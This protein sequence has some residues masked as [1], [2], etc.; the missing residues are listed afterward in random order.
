MGV[1]LSDIGGTVGQKLNTRMQLTELKSMRSIL[2]SEANEK[3]MNAKSDKEVEDVYVDYQKRLSAI[4]SRSMQVAIHSSDLNEDNI[5]LQQNKKKAQDEYVLGSPTLLLDFGSVTDSKQ[6]DGVIAARTLFD[7]S[8][9]GIVAMDQY[10]RPLSKSRYFDLVENDRSND[11]STGLPLRYS[12]IIF[13]ETPENYNKKIENLVTGTKGMI[14]GESLSYVDADGRKRSVGAEEMSSIMRGSGFLKTTTT[15]NTDAVKAAIN[16]I[17]DNL[18]PAERNQAYEQLLSSGQIAQPI[19]IS[20]KGHKETIDASTYADLTSQLQQVRMN[21]ANEKDDAKREQLYNKGLAISKEI[22]A[23]VKD[24]VMRDAMS[25]VETAIQSTSRITPYRNTEQYNKETANPAAYTS[26]QPNMIKAL[27]ERQKSGGGV[28]AWEKGILQTSDTWVT[29][30][31]PGVKSQLA[32]LKDAGIDLQDDKYM[33]HK[34]SLYDL[35]GQFIINDKIMD[36][37]A[38]DDKDYMLFRQINVVGVEPVTRVMPVIFGGKLDREAET[39]YLA[40][41]VEIPHAVAKKIRIGKTRQEFNITDDGLYMVRD[42]Q[43]P[44]STISLDRMYDN[45]GRLSADNVTGRPLEL[46]Q[47]KDG[48]WETTV[49]VPMNGEFITKKGVGNQSVLENTQQGNVISAIGSQIFDSS[50]VG[51]TDESGWRPANEY[52]ISAEQHRKNRELEERISNDYHLQFK[53]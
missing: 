43:D 40:V 12:G 13:S 44:N 26:L 6:G 47:G 22:I 36:K 46:K 25:H 2:R 19:V 27:S 20:G 24:K 17:Y 42:V 15:H 28:S 1:K 32:Y 10:D 49:Y 9:N 14:S 21:F 41:R 4:I 51:Q 50:I 7:Q 48:I 29:A 39:T 11:P 52:E 53:R 38:M 8:V 3:I 23:G 33:E 30:Q 16:N 37:M 34:K 45:S 18:T 35:T 5:L 31:T